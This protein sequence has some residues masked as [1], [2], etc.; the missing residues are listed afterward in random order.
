MLKWL[1]LSCLEPE[2]EAA[3]DRHVLSIRIRT[4]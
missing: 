4:E 3:V 2:A 1:G